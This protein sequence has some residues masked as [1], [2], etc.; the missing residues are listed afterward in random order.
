MEMMFSEYNLLQNIYV[1][2]PNYRASC[3]PL[4]LSIMAA[5]SIIIKCFP[6]VAPP[7]MVVPTGY[8]CYFFSNQFLNESIISLQWSSQF[9]KK[10]HVDEYKISVVPNLL[11]SFCT[12]AGLSGPS[13]SY[14]CSGFIFGIRYNVTLIARNCGAVEGPSSYFTVECKL[15]CYIVNPPPPFQ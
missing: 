10:Y 11:S 1:R 9:I 8:Y 3:C 7:P 14:N 5:T 12:H 15:L 4:T 2:K 13:D 6:H